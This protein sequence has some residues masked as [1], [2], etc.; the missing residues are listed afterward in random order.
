MNFLVEIEKA[1]QQLS[2][3]PKVD[4]EKTMEHVKDIID[5][6]SEIVELFGCESS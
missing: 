1:I 5:F 3:N 4:N 6:T 2:Q